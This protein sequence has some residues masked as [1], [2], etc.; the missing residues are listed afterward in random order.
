[1]KMEEMD[2]RLKG[3]FE[4]FC[5]KAL[6][7]FAE[8]G[9]LEPFIFVITEDKLIAVPMIDKDAIAAD[10]PKKLAE[11]Q[12]QAVIHLTEGWMKQFPSG[13]KKVP[14][15]PVSKMEGREEVL[16]AVMETRQGTISR[17]W[18][19]KRGPHNTADL[20]EVPSPTDGIF[21]SRFTGSYFRRLP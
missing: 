21:E 20:T 2:H 19:M 16:M 17:M 1:M 13:V 7:N 5:E 3:I 12:A 8:D 14:Q 9:K 11:W 4:S 18:T 6:A 15:G 10:L